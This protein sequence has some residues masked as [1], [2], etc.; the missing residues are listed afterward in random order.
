[1]SLHGLGMK[2]VTGLVRL[3]PGSFSDASLF[4]SFRLKKRDLLQAAEHAAVPFPSSLVSSGGVASPIVRR[5]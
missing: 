1:M 2:K 5:L 3:F 4:S